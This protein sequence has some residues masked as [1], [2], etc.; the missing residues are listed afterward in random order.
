MTC[1]RLLVFLIFIS[2]SS[3]AQDRQKVGVVLSG[4]GARGLAHVGVLKALEEA[5]IP[6]DYISGTS[7]GAIIGGLYASGYSINE[8]ESLFLSYNFQNWLQGGT[9]NRYNYYYKQKQ[10]DP[11][12]LSFNFDTKDKF[13]FQFPSSYLNPNQMDYAFMEIFAEASAISNNN[14]D[15]LFIPFFCIATDIQENKSKVLRSGSLARAIRASMT[16]PFYFSP[17]T[18]DGR[19]MFDGGMYNN[20]PADEMLKIYNP[21]IIIGA[22]VAGNYSPPKEGDILSYFQNI[23]TG[24]TNYDIICDNGVM[25]EPNLSDFGI[26]DFSKMERSLKIGYEATLAKIPNIKELINDTVSK[27]DIKKLREDFKS[28]RPD[29]R[30]S[31]INIRGVSPVQ[32][33]FMKKLLTYSLNQDK[34]S[35]ESIRDNYFNLYSDYNIKSIQPQIKFDKDSNNYYLDVDIKT[36]EFLTSKIGG[37]L[38]TNPI[39]HLYLGLD[40]NFMRSQ[41]Y[42]FQANLYAGRYYTSFGLRTRIDY[43]TRLP[44]FTEL[45][46]N[47]NKWSYYRLKTNFFDYSPLNYLVQKERNIQVFLGM[48]FSR[49]DKVVM[50]FGYGVT[51]DDYFNLNNVSVYDTTD[52]TNFKHITTGLTRVYSTLDSPHY[53]NQGVFSKF[54]MQYIFGLEY[55]KPGNTSFNTYESIHNHSWLQFSFKHKQ[56]YSLSKYYSIGLTG[57]IFYSLQDLFSNYNSSLLN[58]GIYSPTLETK[59]Q[60]LPE[61]RA[62]QYVGI[63]LENIFKKKILNADASLRFSGYLFAP[64]QRIITLNNNIPRYSNS[65]FDKYYF[66]FSSALI[67]STPLGPFSIIAGYHQRDDKSENPYTISLSFGYLLFNNKNINR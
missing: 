61:Y 26:L 40:Y 51:N 6:I 57:D 38:S 54:E 44:L 36:K 34:F 37:I 56:Y 55:F 43:S 32:K 22:K 59:T 20:F 35:L 52:Y 65:Y 53:P 23:L 27:E 1:I 41:S 11:S 39:S 28:R 24:Q 2:F 17:I 16:F 50:N 5:N 66:I 14:F 8:I 62:N 13:R 58:A 64:M 63:G 25:I 31:N 19:I 18:I 12:F 42:I 3:F 49:R 48:P 21:D 15:S 60:F 30:I 47:D 10:D 33:E 46:Y 4:G 45:E 67:L 9:D 7:I 29:I